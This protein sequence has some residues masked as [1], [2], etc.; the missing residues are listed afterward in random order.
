MRSCVTCSLKRV[1]VL[2]T[3]VLVVMVTVKVN[4]GDSDGKSHGDG[5]AHAKRDGAGAGDGDDSDDYRHHAVKVV[6]L[7]R[8]CPAQVDHIPL[9]SG[10]WSGVQS[11]SVCN[12][13]VT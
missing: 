10:V 3:T 7:V 8:E 9:S 5:D 6:D 4:S 11:G 1:L 13:V 2:V 12:D